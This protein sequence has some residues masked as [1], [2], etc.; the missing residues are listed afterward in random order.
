[1]YCLRPKLGDSNF[2]GRNSLRSN[3]GDGSQLRGV[4]NVVAG[5]GD[6][7]GAVAAVPFA[8]GPL[9]MLRRTAVGVVLGDQIPIHT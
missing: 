1:M 6:G 3:V 5:G 4:Q 7:V 9:L 2:T 8:D